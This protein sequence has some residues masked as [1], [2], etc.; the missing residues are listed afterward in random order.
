MICY[1]HSRVSNLWLLV[2]RVERASSA[3]GSFSGVSGLCLLS[4]VFPY[5]PPLLLLT[6]CSGQ[7]PRGI[8]ARDD[9]L[10]PNEA[11]GGESE[12]VRIGVSVVAPFWES[13]Q[14]RSHTNASWSQRRN[15]SAPW[16]R[17]LSSGMSPCSYVLTLPPCRDS[18][19]VSSTARR[20]CRSP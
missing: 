14:L 16:C 7:A 10:L 15:R 20:Y 12:I 6:G 18:Q 2:R 1:D 11:S 19:P 17:L 13:E 4:V 5:R 3:T 9:S 8:A